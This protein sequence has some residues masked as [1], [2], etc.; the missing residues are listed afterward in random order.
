VAV[1]DETGGFGAESAAP[2]ARQI[3]AE[4]FGVKGDAKKQVQGGGA[5][6]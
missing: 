5:P 3:L 4:L 2:K 6:D 1:T